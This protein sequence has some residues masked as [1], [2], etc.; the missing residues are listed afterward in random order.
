[1]LSTFHGLEIG[2]RSL[3]AQQLALNTIGHNLSRLSDPNYSRQRVQLASTLPIQPVGVSRTNSA[4]QVGTGVFAERVERVR[5]EFLQTRIL[6][7]EGYLGYWTARESTLKELETLYNEPQT[8]NLK[9]RFEEFVKA[10]NDLA[11]D[12]RES[13]SRE[14]LRD[15]AIGLTRNVQTLFEHFFTLR[16]NLNEQIQT[17]VTEINTFSKQIADLNRE[18]SRLEAEGDSPNDLLDRRD[19]LVEKLSS[20]LE[21]RTS[22]SNEDEFIVYVGSERIV[23]GDQW[24]ALKT[25]ANPQNE[26]LHSVFWERSNHEIFSRTGQLQGLLTARDL[27][28]ETQIQNLNNFVVHLVSTVNEVHQDG[29]SLTLQSQL[30]FFREDFLAETP[31][32][33]WDRDDDG[34][35][36][37]TAV[38]KVSGS[39]VLSLDDQ[40]GTNGTV[41]L[42]IVDGREIQFDYRATDSVKEWIDRL[43]AS[44]SG[45]MA[46]LN[47]RGE[48]TLK[49]GSSSEIEADE[50]VPS[51]MIRHLEDSGNFLTQFSGILNRSGVEGA[52]DWR[53]VGAVNQF[54]L[55]NSYTLSPKSH[56]ARWLGL[57]SAILRD[58]GNIAA[59]RGVD[60]DGDRIVDQITGPNDGSNALRIVSA[61]MSENESRTLGLEQRID[62]H[63]VRLSPE[64]SSFSSYLDQTIAQLGSS[65]RVADLEKEKEEALLSNLEAMR[66]SISGVNVDEEMTSML[67]FQHA[68]QASARFITQVDQLLDT[69]IH[70]MGVS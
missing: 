30:N 69:I 39:Q 66:E 21:I 38:Y 67:R 3:N 54:S 6:D 55:E 2:K 53:T 26:G 8:P 25:R 27:D 12:P 70:R 45:L 63:P 60:T 29:V 65:T 59:S 23:Q 7:E 57:D 52:F 64:S 31:N 20:L 18:I 9:L 50:P 36:D 51:F 17:Q 44:G 5:D 37:S 68:Y 24:E 11:N 48:L 16:Q 43:N 4:G 47:Q 42:G 34:I 13:S 40:I 35:L 15:Q 61:L 33:D 32:G 58:L 41:S 19:T 22:F 56:P 10:W 14:V 1:M 46:Y 28:I 49:A 62:S